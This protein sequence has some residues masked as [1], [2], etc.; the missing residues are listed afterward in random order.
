MMCTPPALLAVG[1]G[2]S[3]GRDFYAAWV[4]R[5]PAIQPV[6]DTPKAGSKLRFHA[7]LDFVLEFNWTVWQ[8]LTA[9]QRIALVDHELS[10]LGRGDE[11]QWI[12]LH[13]DVEEFTGVVKRWGAWQPELLQFAQAIRQLDLFQAA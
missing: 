6:Q 4:H 12:L 11:E 5:H 1:R 10:H 9:E 7:E 13:H 3:V 2:G 8:D